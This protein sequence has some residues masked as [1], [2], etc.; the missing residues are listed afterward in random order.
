M[1]DH[2]T[3]FGKDK[4]QI[5]MSRAERTRIFISSTFDTG[6]KKKTDAMERL[7]DDDQFEKM[8]A[9]GREIN[10]VYLDS[11]KAESPNLISLV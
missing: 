6:A 1:T 11:E 5:G 2:F 3:H 4:E 8:V 9:V 7:Q 10:R